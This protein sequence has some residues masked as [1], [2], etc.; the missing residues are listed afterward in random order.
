MNKFRLLKV[1]GFFVRPLICSSFE[2]LLHSSFKCRMILVPRCTPSASV[3][4]YEP[5][6]QYAHKSLNRFKRKKIFNS[7][8]PCRIPLVSFLARFVRLTEYCH[9]VSDHESRV[10]ALEKSLLLNYSAYNLLYILLYSIK[11][12]NTELSN[13]IVS[14]CLSVFLKIFQEC[15]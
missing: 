4:S 11:L 12:T 5:S 6:L 7:E 8:I 10:K 2:K 3:I 14:F 15:L 1:E 13:N 9:F